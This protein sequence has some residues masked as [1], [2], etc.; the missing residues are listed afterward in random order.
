[1]ISEADQCNFNVMDQ[2]ATVNPCMLSTIHNRF[3]E[4][5][6]SRTV[7]VNELCELTVFHWYHLHY[8]TP[9]K[10]KNEV[11]LSETAIKHVEKPCCLSTGKR[12]LDPGLCG[13]AI[14]G[15]FLDFKLCWAQ[16]TTTDIRF[17]YYVFTNT[18][19]TSTIDFLYS[20][21]DSI[22]HS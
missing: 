3:V 4:N 19:K 12:I 15:T 6:R 20:S 10:F 8:V 11:I 16:V 22:L 13:S 21:D 1:M 2:L 17:H 18:V 9:L 7:Y 5:M 14:V